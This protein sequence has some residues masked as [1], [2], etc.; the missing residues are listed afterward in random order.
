MIIFRLSGGFGNQLWSFAAGYQLAKETGEKYAID[1]ST[2]E[3]P[4]FFRNYDIGH[5]D[6]KFDKKIC[7]KLGDGKLD[8]LFWNHFHRRLGL[9][10]FTPTIKECDKEVCDLSVFDVQKKGKTIYY[11]GDWQHMGYIEKYQDDIRK[12]FVYK[13]KLSD[14]ALKFKGEIS[15][16]GQKSVAV[17]VRRG[18]YVRIG[19]AQNEDY[20]RNAVCRMAETVGRD[21]VFY[22]FSEDIEWVR[23]AF[24]EL[25]YK[26]VY[27]DYESE[28]KDLEDF[29][30]MR[31]CAHQIIS[32]S[33]YS[34]WAAWLNENKDKVVI[35]PHTDNHEDSQTWSDK[36]ICL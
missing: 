26:F 29:E 19:I 23:N 21:A 24:K 25:P 2:Q 18:D 32:R 9:G 34:W 6:I 28:M 7:Y 14:I 36:W 13:E 22:C 15:E 11:V 1:I 16:L 35:Y 17:H 20:Y 5:Y 30:L 10:L 4:W 27:M 3:A 33:T 8:H 12:M 31:I